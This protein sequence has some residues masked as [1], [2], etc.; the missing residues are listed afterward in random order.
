MSK[1]WTKETN[2]RTLTIDMN[3]E[4]MRTFWKEWLDAFCEAA[5]IPDDRDEEREDFEANE[6]YRCWVHG[7]VSDPEFVPIDECITQLEGM[8]ECIDKLEHE[9]DP[10]VIF[11][12]MVFKKNGTFNR[13]TKPVIRRIDFGPYWEDSY[14][15]NV[16]GIRLQAIDDTHAIIRTASWVE[17]Y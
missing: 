6:T 10:E 12:M 1:T 13:S 16:Y 11:A 2:G 4:E 14:G 17:G 3:V 8:M 9:D 5:E 7:G 15:W